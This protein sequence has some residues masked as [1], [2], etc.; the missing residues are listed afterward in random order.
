MLNKLYFWYSMLYWKYISKV[1]STNPNNFCK[2]GKK[3]H[4]IANGPSSNGIFEKIFTDKINKNDDF[5]CLNNMLF[6]RQEEIFKLQP[7]YYVV[8]DPV[9]WGQDLITIDRQNE[10]RQFRHALEKISWDMYLI[11]SPYSTLKTKNPHIKFIYLS[12]VICKKMSD[13]TGKMLEKNMCTAGMDNVALAAIYFGITWGYMEVRLYGVDF[14]YVKNIYVDEDNRLYTNSNHAYEEKAQ[15]WHHF[16]ADSEG[17]VIAY[18]KRCIEMFRCFNLLSVYAKYKGCRVYNMN[19]DSL[20]N[21]FC[22]KYME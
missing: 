13:F 22:K 2:N 6:V 5:L 9:Y 19:K 10:F 15:S 21:M 4:I 7:R 17:E 1:R 20:L 14:D 12:P 16:S 8:V 18:W 11:T 3:L